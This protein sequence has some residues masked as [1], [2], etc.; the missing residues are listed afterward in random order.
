MPPL[1]AELIEAVGAAHV[2]SDDESELRLQSS[3]PYSYH[4]AGRLLP[5]AIALPDSEAQVAAVVRVCA[6]HRVPVVPIAAGTNLEGASVVAPDAG[7][8]RFVCVST[9]R[10]RRIV[11]LNAADLDVVV[12]PG[13]PFPLLNAALSRHGL[14]FPLDAGPNATVGGMIA[15]GASGIRAVRYGPIRNPRALAARRHGPTAPSSSRAAAPR[16]W[17]PGST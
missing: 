15:C 1:L 12:E 11:A 13:V 4:D 17:S 10:M 6:R 16:R 8:V 9:A 2:I 14:V 5:L 3:A 7:V